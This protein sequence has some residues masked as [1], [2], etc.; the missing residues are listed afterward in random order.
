MEKELKT[1]LQE[2]LKKDDKNDYFNQ[3]N[4][5]L[6]AWSFLNKDKFLT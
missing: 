4:S 2:K 3:L 5:F 1:K 6:T